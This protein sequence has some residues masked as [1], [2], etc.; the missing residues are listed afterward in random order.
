M[1]TFR[2]AYGYARNV[3]NA[4]SFVEIRK[5]GTSADQNTEFSLG[6]DGYTLT[7]EGPS[8]THMLPGIYT[9]TLE[10]TTIW[11]DVTKLNLLLAQIASSNDGTYLIEVKNSL[12]A[13]PDFVGVLLPESMAI[14]D[15]AT[16]VAVTFRATDG[17]ALLKNTLYNDDG[18]PYTDHQTLKQHIE[19]VQEKL[20]TWVRN[21]EYLESNVGNRRLA[22]SMNATSVDDASYTT[23]PPS[24]TTDGYERMRVHHRTFHKQ[25]TDGVNEYYSAYDVLDSI[26][27][28]LG[29]CAGSYQQ[30]LWLVSPDSIAEGF[31]VRNYAFNGTETT[32]NGAVLTQPFDGTYLVTTSYKGAN[33]TRSYSSPVGKALLTR[34]TQESQ[35]LIYSTQDA[36]GTVSLDADELYQNADDLTIRGRVRIQKS[37]DSSLA[38]AN[39]LYRFV[40]TFTLIIGTDDTTQY[41][42]KH[43]IQRDITPNMTAVLNEGTQQ[44][45]VV[46]YF[47]LY[48]GTTANDQLFPYSWT[49]SDSDYHY[50]TPME[51]GRF[52]ALHDAKYDIDVVLPFEFTVRVYGTGIDTTPP[53]AHKGA[54][55][56][57]QLLAYDFEGLIDSDYLDDATVTFIEVGLYRRQ[58]NELREAESFR[59]RAKQDSGRTDIDHGQTLIGDRGAST[60]FG[61]IEVYDGTDWIPSSGWVTR[62]QVTPRTVNQMA[63]EEICANHKEAKNVQRGTVVHD[64]SVDPTF[65]VFGIRWQ[66]ITTSQY[67]VP[68]RH[69]FTYTSQLSEVTLFQRGRTFSGVTVD[70]DKFTDPIDTTSLKPSG[71]DLSG[72]ELF[73]V[74][75]TEGLAQIYHNDARTI[76]E[77]WDSANV[78]DGAT[79]EFYKTV[80]PDAFGQYNAY[81]GEFRAVDEKIV[82]RVYFNGRSRLATDTDS[83]WLAIKTMADNSTLAETLDYLQEYVGTDTGDTFQY[84]A[85]ISQERVSIYDTLLDLHEN[86][87]A[88]YSLRKL[89]NAYSGNAIV[90]QRD[91]PSP[92]TTNIGFNA[93]GELDTAAILSFCGSNNGFVQRWY[94]QSG[95]GNDLV[96]TTAANQ[97]LIYNGSSIVTLNGKTAMTITGGDHLP[98]NSAFDINPNVNELVVAWVGSI[99]NEAA[100]RIA[101][102]QWNT[103]STNQVM[104]ILYKQTVDKIRWQHRYDGGTLATADS[105]TTTAGDQYIVVGR[106]INGRHEVLTDGAETVGS[107]VSDTPNNQSGNFAVGARST[108]LN[109]PMSGKTQEVVIWSRAT[110]LDDYNDISD[111]INTHYSSF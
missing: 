22:L 103:G 7:T 13:V 32:S 43:Q 102:S 76:A 19:N 12:V 62:D 36:P 93:S 73:V 74:T 90:V 86:A 109:K 105:A 18:D 104:E 1:S 46:N 54:S 5:V 45:N 92:G 81:S 23:H 83:G 33:W 16:N 27:K 72:S 42:L 75:R 15:D 106:T 28:T 49:T 87:V 26:C 80:T 50:R 6:P 71:T 60:Y 70:I 47:N 53:Y 67:F 3:H 10:V 37:G 56:E 8:D 17:L 68:L 30:A 91:G 4:Q 97:P 31:D 14:K 66:D 99:D 85:V 95:N 111:D 35:G 55:L 20:L 11:D 41:Y 77:A 51:D 25:N 40:P 88:A 98:S 2:V 96:Q 44:E 24:R 63:V 61:G 57:P 65:F 79:L 21:E 100:D 34:V 58:K 107:S 108:G 69:V 94:D 64:T 29:V 101:V 59:Y 52:F 39:R 78:I 84:T 110:A 48:T 38:G 9:K 89:R 82:R